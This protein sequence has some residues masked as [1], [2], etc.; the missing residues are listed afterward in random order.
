MTITEPSNQI[1][2]VDVEHLLHAREVL[3]GAPPAAK[4]TFRATS[5]W[6]DGNQATTTVD[7]FFGLGEEQAHAR[8]HTV[9]TDHPSLF[10]ASDEGATPPELAMMALAGCLTAGIASIAQNWGVKLHKVAATVEADMDMQGILGIDPDVRNGFS[11]VRVAYDI[12]ADT[13]DATVEAIVAQS[14]KRSAVFDIFTNPTAVT[15]EVV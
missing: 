14:Q 2:G 9:V 1:N 8:P 6:V 13:E 11:A 7:G 4:F 5:Q 12:D 15:V 3:T 10:G